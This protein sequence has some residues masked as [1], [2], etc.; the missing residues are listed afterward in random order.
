MEQQ[1]PAAIARRRP[2]G[3]VSSGADGVPSSFALVFGVAG[4]AAVGDRPEGGFDGRVILVP[5][6]LGERLDFAV[7]LLALLLP[8]R[9]LALGRLVL[10]EDSRQGDPGLERGDG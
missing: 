2:Q 3:R 7:V 10:D 6:G 9:L 8:G 4:F 5:E 1:S